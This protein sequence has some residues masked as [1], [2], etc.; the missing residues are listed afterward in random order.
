MPLLWTVSCA[1]TC[2][3]TE[4]N[5]YYVLQGYWNNKWFEFV[6]GYSGSGFKPVI[7]PISPV[8][9]MGRF[10]MEVNAPLL[11]KH[12]ACMDDAEVERIM[13]EISDAASCQD[14][15]SSSMDQ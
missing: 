10:L 3:Q 8:H 6:G 14:G 13:N 12:M 7:K 1:Y 2:Q 4:E 9:G 5:I 11:S 15:S